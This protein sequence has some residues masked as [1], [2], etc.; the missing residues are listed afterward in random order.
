MWNVEATFVKNNT[1]L[2]ASAVNRE[3]QGG[4]R[5]EVMNSLVASCRLVVAALLGAMLAA[6]VVAAEVHHDGKSTT[7]VEQ[8]NGTGQKTTSVVVTPKCQKITTKNGNS[9]D[10]TLQCDGDDNVSDHSDHLPNGRIDPNR[11]ALRSPRLTDCP[12]AGSA[13][14]ANKKPGDK[15]PKNVDCELDGN[16]RSVESIE[17][18]ANR[19]LRPIP[20][21]DAIEERANAR[22]KSGVR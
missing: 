5:W 14:P 15:A 16:L 10:V 4:E 12:P 20:S 8:S 6:S 17:E 11:N 2:A 21:V 3:H 19:R 9:T 22:I 1:P 13:K 18:R 7:V